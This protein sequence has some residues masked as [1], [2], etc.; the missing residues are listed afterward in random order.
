MVDINATE[1]RVGRIAIDV[2]VVDAS[3]K[4]TTLIHKQRSD[5]AA[6]LCSRQSIHM[7]GS[8]WVI[9]PFFQLLTT[10]DL[11]GLLLP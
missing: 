9:S 7:K 8:T 4:T 2:G 5:S 10:S 11:R 6:Q 3:L 1:D